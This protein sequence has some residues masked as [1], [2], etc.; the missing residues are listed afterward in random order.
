M[1][2]GRLTCPSSCFS[3]FFLLSASHT[4]GY[5]SDGPLWNFPVCINP[6]FGRPNHRIVHFGCQQAFFVL[7]AS[8]K[9]NDTHSPRRVLLRP[10]AETC[11]TKA[12][13]CR[14]S[15]LLYLSLNCSSSDLPHYCLFRAKRV[16]LTFS[17]AKLV[18]AVFCKYQMP[19]SSNFFKNFL[20]PVPANKNFSW[21]KGEIIR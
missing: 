16:T 3:S 17:V 4:V 6:F 2:R 18:Q 11:I 15:S 12:L 14:A 21:P 10:M 20:P 1:L 13:D 7:H 9:R 19:Y 5:L 8:L